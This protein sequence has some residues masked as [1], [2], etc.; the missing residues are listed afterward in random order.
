MTDI[1]AGLEHLLYLT[2]IGRVFS[3]AA[4]YAYPARGQLGIAGLNWNT[5]PKDR[6]YDTPFEISVEGK[7]K[8]TQ[9][10]TGD[11]HSLALDDQGRVWSFGDNTYG[12][13][14]FDYHPELQMRDIPTKVSIQSLY[15]VTDFAVKCTQLGAGGLNS[16]YLVDAKDDN[17]QV[18]ADV[19]ASGQG[20]WGALGT[21]TW[22]HAQGQ[23]AKIKTL[24]G[25]VECGC[26]WSY[27]HESCY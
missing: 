4:A 6:P 27:S 2:S 17:G 23:P 26:F 24:S 19:W 16:Y 22:R 20:L 1:S 15:P 5:R 21:G 18:R 14:G 11:Y 9:V 3:S 25:L 7:P 10:A 13:L 12:Q 8:I